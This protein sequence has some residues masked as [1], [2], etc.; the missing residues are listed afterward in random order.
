MAGLHRLFLRK[1][2][3]ILSFFTYCKSVIIDSSNLNIA[4]CVK[5]LRVIIYDKHLFDNHINYTKVS[6]AVSIMTQLKVILPNQILQNTVY[7]GPIH[8]Q[9]NRRILSW[10][11]IFN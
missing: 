4:K 10:G 7:A 2:S 11:A 5:C 9:L 6:R 3:L 8:A 1:K